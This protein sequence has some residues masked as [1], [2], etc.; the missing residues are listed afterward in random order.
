MTDPCATFPVCHLGGQK[1]PSSFTSLPVGSLE[2]KLWAGEPHP[3]A[4][5]AASLE[6]ERAAHPM[7]E[8]RVAALGSESHESYGEGD[9]A[10]GAVLPRP[11]RAS[12]GLH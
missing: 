12:H 11:R 6:E 1:L 3:G 8:L 4:S 2:V 10:A 9:V 5:F 7:E